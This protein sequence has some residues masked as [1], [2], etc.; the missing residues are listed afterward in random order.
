VSPQPVNVTE[1]GLTV[2]TPGEEDATDTV[3]VVEPVRLHPFLPSP[4]AVMT[5]NVVVPF[6]PPTLSGITSAVEST[7]ASTLL[8]TWSANAGAAVMARTT[9]RTASTG[10]RRPRAVITISPR[11]CEPGRTVRRATPGVCALPQVFALW[12]GR[13]HATAAS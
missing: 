10:R 4:L 5:R 3:S 8:L 13:S 7:V 12:R 2:A 11:I 6:G 1:L 9:D